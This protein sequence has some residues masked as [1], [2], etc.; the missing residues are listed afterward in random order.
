MTSLYSE[1]SVSTTPTENTFQTRRR[2]AA[3][4]TQFFGVNY[5]ELMGEIIDSIEKGLEEER[6]KG[7]LKPDEVQVRPPHSFDF[8]FSLCHGILTLFCVTQDLLQKLVKLKGK[9][10]SFN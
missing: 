10:N 9:R 3:K 8:A 5:R 1:F 2:R 4:L 7:T 6:G